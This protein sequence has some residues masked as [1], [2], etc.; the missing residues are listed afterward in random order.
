ME[1]LLVFNLISHSYYIDTDEIPGFL[2]LLKNHIFT[3]HSE[4]T[5]Y[6]FHMWG[7]W[8][9]HGYQHNYS[10]T[11]ELLAQAPYRL[12]WNF[13]HKMALR[14]KDGRVIEIFLFFITILTFSHRK[15]KYYFLYFSF[16]K[17]VVFYGEIPSLLRSTKKNAS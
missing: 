2:L 11:I 17:K 7:Y 3:A 13:I 15:Y 6:I 16:I 1:F 9:G 10:I 12:I 5:I 4:D 8:C 14:C